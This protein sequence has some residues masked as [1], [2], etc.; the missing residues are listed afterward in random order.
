MHNIFQ[1]SSWKRL[2][3]LFVRVWG[4]VCKLLLLQEQA[5]S[6][7]MLANSHGLAWNTMTVFGQASPLTDGQGQWPPAREKGDQQI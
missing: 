5:T 4:I 2:L 3:P 1:L 7:V 6:G